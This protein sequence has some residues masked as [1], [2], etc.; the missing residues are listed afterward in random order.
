MRKYLSVFVVVLALAL[1]A[2]CAFA[3]GNNIIKMNADID[4]PKGTSVNEVISIGGNVTI[5]GRV[6]NNVVV[7]GGTLTIG[8]SASIGEEV[9]VVGAEITRDPASKIEGKI[10]Q[11]YM[12]HFIPSMTTLLKGGWVT[13]WV[14]ISLLVLMGFLGLAILLSA[15]IPEHMSTVVGALERSFGIMLLWGALWVILIVPIAVLLAISIIGIVLIPLE[16]LLVVLALIIGYI[17][18]AVFI[19]KNILASF[20]KPPLPFVDAIL[21]IIILFLIS[22]VPIVGP[23]IKVL[24]V[25]AGFGAVLTTRFGTIK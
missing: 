16:I 20:K 6:E 9:V 24:F 4:V 5:S 17:S 13:V 22:F 7:I 10:T 11:I 25:T 19:G 3:E 15:L 23:V 14:T 2:S 18:V 1:S 12:P 21:G 8:P